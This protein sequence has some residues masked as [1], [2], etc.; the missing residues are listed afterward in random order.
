MVNSATKERRKK[1]RRKKEK[2]RRKGKRREKRK[3]NRNIYDWEVLIIPS[4]EGRGR[5]PQRK[6]VRKTSHTEDL[7]V[8][9]REFL[10]EEGGKGIEDYS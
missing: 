1:G 9:W 5:A 8:C 10:S 7:W 6:L 4:P 3:K 2:E